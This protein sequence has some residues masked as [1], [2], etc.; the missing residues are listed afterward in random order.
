MSDRTRAL[1]VLL[2]QDFRVDDVEETIM[3][4]IKMIKHVIDVKANVADIETYTAY[5]KARHDI[6]TR[7]FD[8]LKD[9]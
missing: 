5:A 2:D 6:Q 4:A 1:T 3:R 8:I 7:L 9:E